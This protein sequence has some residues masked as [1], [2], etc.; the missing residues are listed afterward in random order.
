MALLGLVFGGNPSAPHGVD[1]DGRATFAVRA[2]ANCGGL[3][4]WQQQICGRQ[5]P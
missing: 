2:A 5:P 4:A 3:V 1:Y